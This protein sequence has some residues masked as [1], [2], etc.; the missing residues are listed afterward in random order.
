MNEPKTLRQRIVSG[1]ILVAMR[2]SLATSKNELADLWSTGHYDYVWIDSQHTPYS[3]ERL[4]AYCAAAEELGIDVQLRIPHTRDAH[5]VGRYL[6]FGLSAVLVPEV[7]EPETVD[8]AIAYAHYGPIGRRSWGGLHRR[9]FAPTVDRRAYSDWWN[10]F[11]VLGIQAESVEAVQNIRKLA[12]PGV[13][14]V[15]FG[16]MD[17]SF[18]LEAHPEFPLRNLDDCIRQVAADLE[19][20]GIRLAMGLA[21]DPA[22]QEK[23]L[24]MGI[25][26]FQAEMPS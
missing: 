5:K 20:T 17:L 18:S 3:D 15:T 24:E 10:G 2:G 9:G 16:P 21:T 26:L 23:Y 4:V 12:K 8:D 19:G 25:T 11:V 6:D 1:E 13:S 7:M 14:V 22:D